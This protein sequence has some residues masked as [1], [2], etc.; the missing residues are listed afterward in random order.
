MVASTLARVTLFAA[1]SSMDATAAAEELISRILTSTFDTVEERRRVEQEKFVELDK[2][3][4]GELTKQEMKQEL[5]RRGIGY[6]H[7]F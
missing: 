6:A 3:Q 5:L 1:A 7:Y 4:S 2:D